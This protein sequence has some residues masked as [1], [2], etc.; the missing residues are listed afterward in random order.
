MCVKKLFLKDWKKKE[1]EDERITLEFFRSIDFSKVTTEPKMLSLDERWLLDTTYRIY[2]HSFKMY[3]FRDYA[4]EALKEMFS[5]LGEKDFSNMESLLEKWNLDPLL[6]KAYKTIK[7]L[8]FDLSKNDQ[9]IWYAE[10]ISLT[11]CFFHIGMVT[12]ATQKF[13]YELKM[14]FSKSILSGSGILESHEAL[15]LESWDSLGSTIRYRNTNTIVS[16]A[17]E[18]V[19]Q[20]IQVLSLE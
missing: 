18:I 10:S 16:Q 19:L 4:F 8:K 15:F 1:K 3:Y 13:I 12:Y 2:H 17:K 11:G 6:K 14:N 5:I 20:K 7:D 9:D